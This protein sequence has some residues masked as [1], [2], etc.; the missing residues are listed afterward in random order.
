MISYRIPSIQLNQSQE[1][2]PLNIVQFKESSVD[3]KAEFIP[4]EMLDIF[5]HDRQIKVIERPINHNISQYL[6]TAAPKL[7]S[8]FKCA[9]RAGQAISAKL[10]ADN[11]LPNQA[12]RDAFLADLDCLSD[13]YIDL[14]ACP[15]VSLRIEVLNTAMCPKFH[16]DK[17][18]IRML[19]TYQGQGTQWL[20][21]QYANRAKL[22][23]A[24]GNL[25]DSQSGLILDTQ[26]VHVVPAFAIALLKGSL[27]Q[28]NHMRGIIHRSPAVL[29]NK[30]R[31]MLAIDA[32]W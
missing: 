10:L 27:W 30:P 25:D 12:G 19:C 14:I 31:V 4:L 2:L 5:E 9:V 22:G 6:D 26:A 16:V 29:G 28:G 13:L 8:G 17:T 21:D 1:H 15:Q 7:A 23:M 18:G 24:S 32:V 3:A 11:V 20:D